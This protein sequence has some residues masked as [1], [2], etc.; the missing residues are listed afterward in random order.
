MRSDV[1]PKR[2]WIDQICID[3]KDLKDKE[4]QVKRMGDIY[5]QAMLVVTYAGPESSEDEE[6]IS[7]L[8]TLAIQYITPFWTHYLHDDMWKWLMTLD[9]ELEDDGGLEIDT[10]DHAD[11]TSELSRLRQRLRSPLPVHK[12]W[13]GLMRILLGSWGR[14]RWMVQENVLN[15]KVLILRGG[16]TLDQRTIL[17]LCGFL[18]FKLWDRR[19]PNGGR[20]SDEDARNLS[21]VSMLWRIQRVVM[22]ETQLNLSDLLH[23]F[24][25]SLCSDPR[26]AVYA[27]LSLA[28]D[29]EALGIEA[30]YSKSLEDVLVDT[31]VAMLSKDGLSMYLKQRDVPDIAPEKG[32]PSWV[33]MWAPRHQA[34]GLV[35]TSPYT[36]I[37][38]SSPAASVLRFQNNNR[39]LIVKAVPIG[40]ISRSFGLVE[41]RPTQH[42]QQFLRSPTTA[43]AHPA[44]QAFQNAAEYL[45]SQ[46]MAEDD[47]TYTL[48]RA[49][50]ATTS[51][52]AHDDHAAL[53]QSSNNGQLTDCDECARHIRAGYRAAMRILVPGPNMPHG[54]KLRVQSETLDGTP[55][56]SRTEIEAGVEFIRHFGI[57]GAQLALAGDCD[58]SWI[59]VRSRPGDLIF[60]PV[61]ITTTFVLRPTS[62]SCQ[63][64]RMVG[65]AFVHGYIDG[66]A[67]KLE[68]GWEQSAQEVRIV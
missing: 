45:S 44:G 41:R 67:F 9:A 26:D 65:T 58:L 48:A 54:T 13:G 5:R 23:W 18:L 19:L 40:A 60:K 21:N 50:L 61:G 2:F 33:P 49:F 55:G 38:L 25:N 39:V 51:W 30:D 46:G 14:R 15:P 10:T 20:L 68:H 56:P 62:D 8:D 35:Q 24:R 43:Q 4:A 3:Q 47:V 31:A 53:T 22:T 57:H 66:D 28:Q 6:A 34:T 11:A 12:G 63:E 1:Q 17:I 36:R 29:R 32:V 52:K 7:L 59:P 37:K 16:R 64:Y 42:V 27:L